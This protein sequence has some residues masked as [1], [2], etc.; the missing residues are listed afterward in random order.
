MK[1]VIA[2]DLDGT[3]APSKSSISPQMDEALSELLKQKVVCVISGGRFEQFQSQLLDN[4]SATPNE[5]SNLHLMPTSGTHYLRYLDGDWQTVYRE[6]IPEHDREQIISA[7]QAAVEEYG[8]DQ[9]ETYGEQ[10]EDRKSQVTLSAF[11]QDIVEHLGTKGVEIKEN[12]DPDYSKRK[13]MVEYLKPRLP[14]GVE[15]M[16]GGISSI[17][18]VMRGV[19]KSYG[20]KKLMQ[21]LS[22]EADD[23]LFIGDALQEGGNDYPVK[24]VGIDT[25]S[26]DS[27]EQTLDEIHNLLEM[28]NE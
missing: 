9:L 19:D 1:K 13:E 26:V 15:A 8:Y 25:I 17:D 14:E 28:I 3:L 16:I 22:L 5:Y 2:F 10:I 12:W 24:K 27:P 23:V 20:M 6:I 11:G 4:F 7:L 18:V 21:E